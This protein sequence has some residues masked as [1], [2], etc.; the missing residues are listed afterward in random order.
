MV[1]HQDHSF[2]DTPAVYSR[3]EVAHIRASAMNPELPL[4]CPRCG[5][6]LK[7]GAAIHCQ[8]H[9]AGHTA[10]L[11]FCPVC[12]RCVTV[13][14]I[15]EGRAGP[16]TDAGVAFVDDE[17]RNWQVCAFRRSPIGAWMSEEDRYFA[18]EITVVFERPGE[19]RVALTSWSHHWDSEDNLRRLFPRAVERRKG[20]DRRVLDVSV[21][22]D[23]RSGKERRRK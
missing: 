20:K 1:S 21:V 18:R 5:E 8:S 16:V 22:T 4:L 19:E 3:E 9:G 2:G 13:K 23:R 17:G 14:D 7:V 10:R 6:G 11:L 15:P 12:H